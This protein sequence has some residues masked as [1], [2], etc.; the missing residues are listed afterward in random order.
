MNLKE[1]I[2][3]RESIRNYQERSLQEADYQMIENYLFQLPLPKGLHFSLMKN[4]EGAFNK[5]S[6]SY[7][8]FKGVSDAIVVYG[9]SKDKLM[10]EKSGYFGYEVSLYLVTQGID[11]CF[12]GGTY[13]KLSV[14]V[15][16]NDDEEIFYLFSIGRRKE[17]ELLRGELMRKVLRRHHRESSYFIDTS[18]EYPGWINEGLNAMTVS[19][20]ATN[21]QGIIL[22]YKNNE[23][24]I[25]N[26]K[27]GAYDLVDLGIAK[28]LFE[29]ATEKGKFED[30][31]DALFQITK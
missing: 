25:V 23:L 7:G 20:S 11:N 18:E 21:R 3:I 19:P 13:D 12:V 30:G 29:I 27:P 31:D 8:F 22:S 2:Y 10:L 24:R 15:T 1:A 17:K 6:K 4:A 5:L 9:K 26:K 16:M 14:E 28:R